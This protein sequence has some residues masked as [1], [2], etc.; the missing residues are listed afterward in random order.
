MLDTSLTL[1]SAACTDNIHSFRHKWDKF[2]SDSQVNRIWG[3]HSPRDYIILKTAELNT[4][5]SKTG[6]L[7]GC[8]TEAPA[9]YHTTVPACSEFSWH[10]LSSCPFPTHRRALLWIAGSGA[11]YPQLLLFYSTPGPSTH[12]GSKEEKREGGKE[13]IQPQERASREWPS[14]T[15]LLYLLKKE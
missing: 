10:F 5:E 13:A 1:K 15:C 2:L 8:H 9:L 14:P 4:T 11:S 7:F 12:M 6:G 3:S